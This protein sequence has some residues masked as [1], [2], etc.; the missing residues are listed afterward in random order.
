MSY[1]DNS[2]ELDQIA[3]LQATIAD[4]QGQ[5]EVAQN[6]QTALEKSVRNLTEFYDKYNGTPCEQIRHQQEVELLQQRVAQ[7][8]GERDVLKRDQFATHACAKTFEQMSDE[9]SLRRLLASLQADHARVLGL[10]QEREYEIKRRIWQMHGS[11]MGHQLYG[12]DG[13]LDCNTCFRKYSDESLETVYGFEL[14]DAKVLCAKAASLPA[15]PAQGGASKE[16]TT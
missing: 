16:T 3:D 5:L 7:L 8:E 9:S 13:R 6:K 15:Q 1:Y 2:K 12:D 14:Y 10:V 4:L 11:R